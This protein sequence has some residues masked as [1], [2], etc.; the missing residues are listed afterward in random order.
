MAE[1]HAVFAGYRKRGP[2]DSQESLKL[3]GQ[4]AGDDFVCIMQHWA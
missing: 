1:Q 3:T 2:G 4:Q